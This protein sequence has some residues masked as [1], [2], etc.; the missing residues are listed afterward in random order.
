MGTTQAELPDAD[1]SLVHPHTRGDHAGMAKELIHKL[2]SPPHAWGPRQA[3]VPVPEAGR[4]TPTRVGTTPRWHRSR[5][6]TAVHPHTR[7]DH[8]TEPVTSTP[9]SGSPPHAWGPRREG[10]PDVA[11]CRFT[12]T[13]VGTTAGRHRCHSRRP[14]HPHTRGDHVASLGSRKT[15]SGSP[16]HAWGPL[17]GIG[18]AKIGRRF[19]PTRVGTTLGNSLFF[20]HSHQKKTLEVSN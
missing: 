18:V 6:A 17:A 13:R 9:H 16:P 8:I 11:P 19:T 12:P 14:V 4:F 10:R 5:S 3:A 2:G 20:R 1:P 7:G 15:S